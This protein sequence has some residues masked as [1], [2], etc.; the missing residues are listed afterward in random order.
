MHSFNSAQAMHINRMIFG[1]T[2]NIGNPTIILV[3]GAWHKAELYAPLLNSLTRMRFPVVAPSLPSVGGTSDNFD[4]DV[5]LIREA[6]AAEV[7]E[8][9]D[10]IMVMH[11][12]GG[13]V[14]SAAVKG[15]SEQ[16]LGGE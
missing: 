5:R 16:E 2:R 11:S 8:G 12:Y 13:M 15:Y 10:I 1:S 4:D 9:H 6:I 7:L 14:G 3:P